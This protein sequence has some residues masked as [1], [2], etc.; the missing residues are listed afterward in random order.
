MHRRTFSSL[1]GPC[2]LQPL[3][4]SCDNQKCLQFIEHSVEGESS[5]IM[6]FIRIRISKQLVQGMGWE[7][8][9]VAQNWSCKG[10]RD[11][12][13]DHELFFNK[14]VLNGCKHSQSS[15]SL[16]GSSVDSGIYMCSYIFVKQCSICTESTQIS[17]IL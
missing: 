4:F 13:F 15:V 17:C 1:S 14:D 9:R 11:R 10:K 8:R 5:C 12:S 7:G 6:V 16:V 2:C 3:L